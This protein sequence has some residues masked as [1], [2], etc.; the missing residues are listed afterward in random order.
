MERGASGEWLGA[1]VGPSP[2][3]PHLAPPLLDPPV[4]QCRLEPPRHLA[5]PPPP[6]PPGAVA[7]WAAAARPAHRLAPS[8]L[9]PPRHLAPPPLGPPRRSTRSP[10][11]TGREEG[12][13]DEKR[14]E[15][16]TETRKVLAL[17]SSSSTVECV[18]LKVLRLG[19][20]S[21]TASAVTALLMP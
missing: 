16:A 6:H 15:R 4:A 5:L 8:Q 17:S 18:T 2:L 20:S 11:G 14:R 1:G 7:A 13:R 19:G 10:P 3:N 12:L 9:G 21:E